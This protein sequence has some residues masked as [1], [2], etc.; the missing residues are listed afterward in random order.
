MILALL[1][2]GHV[3]V[4][5]APGLAKTK[6]LRLL[7]S[8]L[9]LT[10]KRIQFTPDMLPADIIGIEMFNQSTQSFDTVF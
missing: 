6:T 3:L 9:D 1:A 2:H 7:A 10:T 8:L 4:E 5:G